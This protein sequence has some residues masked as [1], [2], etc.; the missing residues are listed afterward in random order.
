MTED[1]ID[2]PA[3]PTED[4]TNAP[5]PAAAPAA[6]PAP[7][8][9]PASPAPPASK[10]SDTWREDMAG[11]L[12]ETA[13]DE[14]KAEHDKLLKRLRRFN[15]PADAARA[16]R[17]Q[18]KL[19]SS[20]ALKKALPKNP[21]AE[22]LA[23]WRKDHGIPEKADGYDLGLA[24]DVELNDLDREMLADWAAQAHAVNATPEAVQAGAKAYVAM[25]AKVA[26]QIQQRNNEARDESMRVLA[27]EWGADYKA[28]VA[29]VNSMLAAA[30]SSAVQSL[31]DL[32]T[33]DGVQAM[34]NPAIMG[35]LSEMART[36]G[37]TGHTLTPAGADLGKSITD[38]LEGMKKRMR[39]EPDEWYRDKKAQERFQQL[40]ESQR[41]LERNGR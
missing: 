8:A 30:E 27:Q 32:R 41:R 35:W 18:D 3:S 13:T 11:A 31:L 2:A 1:V 9:S 26:E 40:V 14:D 39:T 28:N 37:Y 21:T 6:A 15:T 19:I 12:P 24:K 22:Q 16:L 5:A 36:L 25:R 33:S 17:E 4:T 10:W 34:N 20:G 23:D 29:G 38:E 7:A